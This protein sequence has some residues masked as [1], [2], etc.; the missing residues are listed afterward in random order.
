MLGVPSLPS[1]LDRRLFCL[2]LPNRASSARWWSG[3]LIGLLALECSPPELVIDDAVSKVA[4]EWPSLDLDLMGGMRVP[5]LR[6]RALGSGLLLVWNKGSCAY[7]LPTGG[8]L[9]TDA[10]GRVGD[11][12]DPE[13]SFSRV[14]SPSSN[15]SRLRGRCCLNR[16]GRLNNWLRWAGWSASDKEDEL[17]EHESKTSGESV[18]SFPWW[19]GRAEADG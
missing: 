8:C 1:F 2:G 10:K 7:L 4:C 14:S 6:L 13:F 17:D 18:L 5:R 19:W 16:G 9:A 12:W 15:V 3:G 11:P